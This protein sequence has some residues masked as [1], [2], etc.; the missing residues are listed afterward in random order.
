MMPAKKKASTD[1][2]GKASAKA[3]TDQEQKCHKQADWPALL[4]RLSL[5]CSV[6]EAHGTRLGSNDQH[7]NQA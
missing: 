6:P 1:T 2:N 5:E 7:E 4:C 3:P